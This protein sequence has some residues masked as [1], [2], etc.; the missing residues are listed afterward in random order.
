[1]SI[2]LEADSPLHA[3]LLDL[4]LRLR[5]SF[6]NDIDLGVARTQK[7]LDKLGNPERKIPPAIH[8]A[9][10]NGKGSTIAY[11]RA[12]LEASGRQVHVYTSPHLVRFNERIRLRGALV[13]DEALEAALEEAQSAAGHEPVTF[14]ELATAAA[15]LL[16]SK[17]PGDVTLLETGL[18]GRLDATNVI[19]QPLATVITPVSLDHTHLLGETLAAIA[20]EKACIQKPGSVSIV[21]PQLPEAAKVIVDYALERRIP[22]Y[23]CGV[24]WWGYS[25]G[26]RLI[27]KSRD[28]QLSLPSPALRGP[29]QIDNAATA[30][31][32]IRKIR[33]FPVRDEAIY[34]GLLSA[35]WPARLQRLKSGPLTSFLPPSIEAW[36]DGAHNTAGALALAQTLKTWRDKPLYLILG[37]LNTK[38]AA[39]FI[40]ALGAYAE[41]I[42]TVPIAGEPNSFGADELAALFGREGFAAASC[43]D[44]KEAFKRII[45][46]NSNA[47]RIIITGSLYLAGK[48]LKANQEYPA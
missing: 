11:L 19:D 44:V 41:K 13:S 8:V 30:V 12:I 34:R 47:G 46:H 2:A 33:A 21:G 1:M 36:L 15:F 7:L 9:G 16:F 18:G 38:D 27:F 39:A 14:F 31:A 6:P 35:V 32:A 24:E 20:Y 40:K 42:Y 22:L 45:A 5:Q 17:V 25:A 28:E 29:H 23:R 37:M 10:T 4:A 48:V 3:K 43:L 26:E